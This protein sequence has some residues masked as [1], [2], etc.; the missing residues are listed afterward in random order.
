MLKFIKTCAVSI[1]LLQ[2]CF[3]TAC[4]A[5]LQPP[6]ATKN[7]EEISIHNDMR[8]DDYYWLRNTDNPEVIQYLLDWNAYTDGIMQETEKL[9][10]TLIQE[11]FSRLEEESQSLPYRCGDYDYFTRQL[12]SQDHPILYRQK[13]EPNATEELLMDQNQTAK[14]FPYFKVQNWVPSPNGMYLAYAIDLVGTEYCSILVQNTSTKE[15]ISK[16]RIPSASKT[17]IWN[18]NSQG[19]WYIIPNENFRENKILFHEMGTTSAIDRLV[20]EEID[21]AFNLSI[22]ESHDNRFIFI[23]SL[24]TTA[25]EVFYLVKN[26]PA[27]QL[28][29]IA[30][31]LADRQYFPES[32]KDRFIIRVKNG[33][34]NN[35]IMT[36][37]ISN[38]SNW[39]MYVPSSAMAQIFDSH[40]FND[41]LVL[42][43]V[44]KGSIKMEIHHLI[45]G[46]TQQVPFPD[47][48]Y[49]AYVMDNQDFKSSV[50]YI[51][52]SSSVTPDSIFFY[53]MD[54]QQL[55]LLKQ[56]KV[57]GFDPTLYTMKWEK[58]LAEDGTLIPISLCYR[59]DA[60]RCGTAPLHLYAYGAYEVL[61]FNSFHEPDYSLLDRGV[62]CAVAH[63]RGGGECGRSWY[64]QGRHLNKKNTFTDFIC[65]AEHLIK[66]GYA[67]SSK[68]VIE[69]R[70]AGGLLVGG[71]INMRPDLFKAAIAE[72]PFVDVLTTMNDVSIPYVVQEYEEWG[73]SGIEEDYFY[74]KE[75][76]PYDNVE[77]KRYPSLLVTA[78]FYDAQVAYWEGAKWVAKLLE[79]KTDHNPLLFKVNMSAGHQSYSDRS[80]KLQEVAFKYAFIL[81]QL[82]INE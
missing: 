26:D 52:Y 58:A 63:V 76:S 12:K 43:K 20:Y 38:P 53:D 77:R 78:G 64:E 73:N 24:S 9:Q 82:E 21:P 23:N 49:S 18:D 71:V 6:R 79:N 55:S 72:V 81:Q 41:Y 80:L 50:L 8:F 57:K 61:S 75:Y 32:Y 56:R 39:T 36:T 4:E 33:Q 68:M 1:C 69:G 44:E 67:S 59:K 17:L 5:I 10:S 14:E 42:S 15:F 48:L 28:H 40:I 19:F 70:S 13:R 27:F 45:T 25:S 22:K 46:D 7:C 62:I 34:N 74:M 2:L 31:R 11:L 16:D 30:P 51:E 54:N 65:C 37:P 35:C 29:C 47:L 66:Q 60:L 3:T